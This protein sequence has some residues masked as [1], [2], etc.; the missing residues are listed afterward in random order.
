MRQLLGKFVFAVLL[1]AAM[2]AAHAGHAMAGGSKPPPAKYPVILAHGM[3]GFD[4]LIGTVPYFY[5]IPG[6]VRD[7]GHT[8]FTS[9]VSSFNSIAVRGEQLLDQVEEIRAITGK[10]KVNIIGHS[11]GGLDARYVAH[12]LGSG[13]VASV[14]TMGT[15]HRGAPIADLGML[16]LNGDPT[17]ITTSLLNAVAVIFGGVVTNGDLSLPQDMAVQLEN[18]S[19]PFLNAWNQ[20]FT[21][22]SGVYYQSYSG[23]SVFNISLDPSDALLAITSVIFGFEPNDGLVGL[24]SSGWGNQRNLRL[25]ANHLD[26]VDQVLGSTGLFGLDARGLYK[27]IARDLQKRGY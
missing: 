17:G 15:P 4:K 9:E 1:C 27:D 6:A 10:S 25:N 7:A 2:I 3:G 14:T 19:S 8:V 24:N 26:E 23:T 20:Q 13:K 12:V 16:I 22:A 18:L 5:R 11:M 21:N